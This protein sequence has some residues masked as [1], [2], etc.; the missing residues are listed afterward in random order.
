MNQSK[1]VA[2]ALLAISLA[3]CGGDNNHASPAPTDPTTPTLP[4]PE[5]PAPETPTPETP[6]PVA[7]VYID[8]SF[9]GLTALPAGWSVPAGNRGT[10][11]VHDGSLF[12]DG[13]AHSS[14]MTAVVLPAS[15]Q[16]LSNYRID[17]QF[18]IESPNN[19]TRWAS[20]M[21]RTSAADNA[22]PYDPY[23][24]FA[25]RVTATASNGTEFAQRKN[26]QWLV[27]GT[28]AFSESINPAKTY[29][30]TVIVHGNRVRHY[31]DNML[32]HDMTLDEAMAKGG[33][34][35]QTTGAVMRVDS[36]K[37]TQQ[38]TALPDVS[39][40]IA[41]QDT[42]TPASMAPTLVQ[43][44]SAQT[45]LAGSGASNAL[46]LIDSSL[47]LR[48]ES[49]ES[50]ASLAHY[51]AQA[52]RNTIPVLRIADSA[53]VT[54]LAEF[55]RTNND[56]GDVT[57]L[58]DN[59]ELL[60][61]A[62]RAI[63]AVRTAVDF[64]GVSILGNTTQDI[65]QVVS[66]TNRAKAKIA[67]L[68]AAMT[69]RTTV[70][71]LQRLLL[72]PWAK[73]TAAT[74]A[75][76]A[77]VLT[78][79]VNGV[80]AANAAVYSA[81]LKQLPANTLLRKPL[82]T[83]HRGMP[84]TT[85][86]NTLEGARAAVAAGADAVENDI[87]MTTDRHLVIMHD[88][89]VT[90]TTTGTGRIEDMTLAQ[91]KA[92]KTK[93]SGYSVPTLQEFF[94]EFKG[95][96]ISHFIELKSTTAGIVPLLKEELEK[97]G[98]RDQ[99]VAISFS[100]D[101]LNRMAETLPEISTGFLNSSADAGDVAV[102][103]RN[104]L[105]GTQLYSSTYNPSFGGLTQ[106]TMEAGKHRGTTFWPWTIN[107]ENDF[108]RFYSYGTHGITTDHAYWA[109]DFPV[110]ISTAATASATIGSPF[111]A[112]VDLSTQVGN[113]SSALS[114]QMVVLDGSPAHTVGSDG[115]V[116]FTAAGTATVLPGYTHKMG[117]GTYSYTI[118]AK[119]MTVQV[120]AR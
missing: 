112:A 31:L 84:G 55:A 58:S 37:V 119:P 15:L 57:L 88:D 96:N 116:T 49:G 24:Q 2:A 108:Y 98:V 76:A 42:G 27:T 111:A 50:L 40:V 16:A 18:T 81:V 107:T 110:A 114:N 53:T 59:V 30:A 106:A 104:I 67:V 70:A 92:L 34:G 91:V 63:P 118:F 60:A 51:F 45:Q 26:G 65:L 68:P 85:D 82:V 74:P 1:T 23:Y 117:A 43:P 8:E 12:I 6:A 105:N 17:A 28:K 113:A 79:G 120:G 9:E 101:Q 66:A 10:V 69:N 94:A 71:H 7:E 29:A 20:V 54:A 115:R 25:V 4:T 47:N 44:M 11:S 14:E 38:L 86:E 78:T 75:A 64:S 5:T 93:I 73:S 100:G 32:T 80:I 21:Y 48:S 22:R 97:A 95:R 19:A 46:F 102:N 89:T 56:L 103:L 109:K 77:E 99:V 3:A 13:R 39:K 87:Y 61:S 52:D 41:V 36:I 83:G 72:T 33:I 35:L 62:R 90:R